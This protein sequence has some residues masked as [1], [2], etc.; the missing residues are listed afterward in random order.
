MGSC[1]LH[2]AE[3]THLDNDLPS[4]SATSD[5]AI[6]NTYQYLLINTCPCI[7]VPACEQSWSLLLLHL[8][9]FS[10]FSVYMYRLEMCTY[11]AN[12]I[13]QNCKEMCT[14][15]CV[16]VY[17]AV[18]VKVQMYVGCVYMLMLAPRSE[19]KGG[20][21]GCG[22]RFQAR[23]DDGASVAT[24]W[25]GLVHQGLSQQCHSLCLF[26]LCNVL[27][28]PVLLLSL[29]LFALALAFKLCP[30]LAAYLR[31]EDDV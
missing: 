5:T 14:V 31:V 9:T 2:T 25:L 22:E 28:L 3:R 18:K 30:L 10:S 20:G 12:N 6:C 26:G 15:F 7:I 13:W 27:S 4:N 11:I 16:L 17:Y 23:L 8:I 29:L 21:L 19:V 1:T 24:D